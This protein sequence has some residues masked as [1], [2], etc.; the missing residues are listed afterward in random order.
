MRQQTLTN[1][2]W[3]REYLNI[4]KKYIYE[5]TLFSCQAKQIKI[6][7]LLSTFCSESLK[8]NRMKI[9]RVKENMVQLELSQL[10][11]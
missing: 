10:V 7:M 9:P 3:K 5:E 1:T 11:V 6:K 8:L 2:L 4:K